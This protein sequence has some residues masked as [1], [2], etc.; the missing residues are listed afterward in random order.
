MLCRQWGG[1]V[2]RPRQNR[3]ANCL[4]GSCKQHA[5]QYQCTTSGVHGVQNNYSLSITIEFENAVYGTKIVAPNI[6][7]HSL[8][9]AEILKLLG[10]YLASSAGLNPHIHRVEIFNIRF[11]VD[12]FLQHFFLLTKLV[13]LH[14]EF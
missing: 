9:N 5:W 12:S 1:S 3:L 6:L 4:P 8:D 14:F 2:G 7:E 13:Y 10:E 11:H